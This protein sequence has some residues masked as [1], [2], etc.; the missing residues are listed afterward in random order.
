M[1]KHLMIWGLALLIH[2]FFILFTPYSN[3]G[4]SKH[5]RAV[6]TKKTPSLSLKAELT[7]QDGGAQGGASEAEIL[8]KHCRGRCTIWWVGRWVAEA[9]TW[10]RV[11]WAPFQ[12]PSKALKKAHV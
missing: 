3:L 1:K 4:F 6:V 9:G 10:R 11:H 12:S 2:L 8:Y 5:G 7:I